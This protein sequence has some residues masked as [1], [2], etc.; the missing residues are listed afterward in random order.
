MES[1]N[2]PCNLW[3]DRFPLNF[4]GTATAAPSSPTC[5]VNEDEFVMATNSQHH[6]VADEKILSSELEYIAQKFVSS[7]LDDKTTPRDKKR[8]LTRSCILKANANHAPAVDI[9]VDECPH[10]SKAEYHA[11]LGRARRMATNPQ[12]HQAADKKKVC[13]E[14]EDTAQKHIVGLPDVDDKNLTYRDVIRMLTQY[15]V[16]VVDADHAP[17]VSRFLAETL[18]L[19]IEEF[20][21]VMALAN[22]LLQNA[23]E[24]ERQEHDKEIKATDASIKKLAEKIAEWEIKKAKYLLKL[25]G[26]IMASFRVLRESLEEDG[27]NQVQIRD[28]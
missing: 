19:L 24:E 16:F 15:F 20:N 1:A 11:V 23:T 17:A 28:G 21:S 6:Q 4:G 9:F 2:G 14:V 12:P 7:L 22:I 5:E 18:D 27:Q 13:V 3:Q 26:Q 25:E 8:R 10:L